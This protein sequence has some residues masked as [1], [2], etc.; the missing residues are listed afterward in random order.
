MAAAFRHA[1]RRLYGSGAPQ[2][3]QEAVSRRLSPAAEQLAHRRLSPLFSH[4]TE[5]GQPYM[6]C[7]KPDKD[8]TL[9]LIE[10]KK[11]EL[12]DLMAEAHKTYGTDHNS[13][14]SLM[15]QQ[16]L[17]YLSGHVKPRPYDRT[18]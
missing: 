3:T 6:S 17:Q 11:E 13:R 7:G 1:A 18:W 15:N 14:A 5:V 12:Y 4:T 16:L 9:K 2:Q 10:R 8:G